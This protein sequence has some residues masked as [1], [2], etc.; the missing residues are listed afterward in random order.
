MEAPRLLKKI[1]ANTRRVVGE[2]EMKDH[3]K[4][5]QPKHCTGDWRLAT[6]PETVA[7]V[8]A[9]L[10]SLISYLSLSEAEE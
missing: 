3:S 2:I 10:A 4:K 9:K 5:K 7:A 8:A 6:P 1:S